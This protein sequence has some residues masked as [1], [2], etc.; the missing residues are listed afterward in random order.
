MYEADEMPIN[1]KVAVF[2]IAAFTVLALLLY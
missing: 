1:W 2:V